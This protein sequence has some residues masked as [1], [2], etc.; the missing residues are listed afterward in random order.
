MV[1]DA[2]AETKSVAK[3]VGVMIDTKMNFFEQI[4]WTAGNASK[5][6]TSLGRLICD[7]VTLYKSDDRGPLNGFVRC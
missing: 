5:G 3:Y 7:G 4:R 6:V 2:T 1:G